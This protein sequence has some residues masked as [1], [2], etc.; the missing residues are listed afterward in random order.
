MKLYKVIAFLLLIP[1]VLLGQEISAALNSVE[2][3]S[4]IVEQLATQ[5]GFTTSPF[6]GVFLTSLASHF[7]IGNE[8]IRE[9][10]VF[11]STLVLVIS[12]FLTLAAPVSAL[13]T[14]FAPPIKVFHGILTGPIQQHAGG[15]IFILANIGAYLNQ[16]LPVNPDISL[17]GISFPFELIFTL[18]VALSYFIMISA[19]NMMIDFFVLVIP[20]PLIDTILISIKYAITTGLVALSVFFPKIALVVLVVMYVLAYLLYKRAKRISIKQR[21][22][23]IDPIYSRFGFL[24]RWTLQSKAQRRDIGVVIFPIF[25]SSKMQPFKRYRRLFICFDD[26]EVKLIQPRTL[27]SKQ[28]VSNISIDCIKTSITRVKLFYGETEIGYTS[29]NYRKALKKL[30]TNE[31]ENVDDAAMKNLILNG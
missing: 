16:D 17:A 6:L 24:K 25:L 7:N 3:N 8:F 15:A 12:G 5:L 26:N 30:V 2:S 20:L 28:K 23:I 21:L 22:L 13:L 1:T 11:G 27:F 29:L 19:V 10:A 14:D 31:I 9:S 18:F 4:L